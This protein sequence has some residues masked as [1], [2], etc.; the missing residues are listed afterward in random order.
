VTEKE[1]KKKEGERNIGR[2]RVI[3]KEIKDTN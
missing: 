2:K 1:N 3:G